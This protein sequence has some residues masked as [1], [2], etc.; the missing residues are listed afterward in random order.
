MR[1]R[2]ENKLNK[3]KRKGLSPLGVGNPDVEKGVETFNSMMDTGNPTAAMGESLEEK[4]YSTLDSIIDNMVDYSIKN[5]VNLWPTPKAML[6]DIL[7]SSELE[8]TLEE[9]KPYWRNYI[10]TIKGDLEEGLK[11]KPIK[12]I[13][14]DE[15]D[16]TK[17]KSIFRKEMKESMDSTKGTIE[18][19]S[20][21][22][23][24]A[25]ET[26]KPDFA[27]AVREIKRNNR[28]RIEA[29]KVRKA[30][31]EGEALPKDLSMNYVLDEN[32]I[33][34]A[35]KLTEGTSNFYSMEN[36]PLVAFEVEDPWNDEDEEGYESGIIVLSRE[37]FK[38]L[39][40]DIDDFNYEIKQLS[41][42]LY[43]EGRE[44]ES[45]TISDAEVTVKDGYYE[46]AQLIFSE[47]SIWDEIPKEAQELVTNFFNEMIKKYNLNV[48]KVAYRFSNGETGY[49]KIK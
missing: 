19:I 4:D 20:D 43:D 31:E 49:S 37:E 17:I 21:V 9:I 27:A 1:I 48:L 32:L 11:G 25:I 35:Y 15:Q 10:K 8:L 12:D 3:R 28:N 22:E 26:M 34:E 24:T 2:E 33:Y 16:N 6:D 39:E 38:S 40:D 44:E 7:N 23:A 47:D 45:W 41:D 30:P 42:K 13:T 36:L 46:G 14:S 29:G 5:Q 18:N